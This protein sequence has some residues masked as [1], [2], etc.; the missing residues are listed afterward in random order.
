VKI[1]SLDH[2]ALWIADRDTLADFLTAHIGMHVIERTDAFT[3]VGADARRGKLTLF[4]VDGDE[5]LPGPL[6]R[7][8]LR[9]TDLPAA[10]A[11]LP[12][13]LEVDTRG[14]VAAFS[15]PQSLALGLVQGE[16][17]DYDLDHVVLRA[18]DPKRC[19]G[20][21]ATLGFAADDGRL[22]VGDAFLALEGADEP[23]EEES[24]FN[25]L[26]LRVASASE[27]IEEARRRGLE[28]ADV[29]DGPNTLAVFVWGPERIKLEYVEHKAGFSLV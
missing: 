13:D 4:A 1:E 27:H 18:S 15:A 21:L 3:I 29:V 19:F 26:G 5:R 22:R 10:L 9:V 16:G 20:E 2:V 23:P 7:I 24:I 11:K 12:P 25:H 8:V 6:A 28:I 17:V 14:G